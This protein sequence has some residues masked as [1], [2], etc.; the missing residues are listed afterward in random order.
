MKRILVVS[1]L[2]IASTANSQPYEPEMVEIK[3]GVFFMGSHGGYAESKPVHAVRVS[4]FYMGK[5][6]VTN[7]EFAAFIEDSGYVTEAE[8]IGT[9]R[10]LK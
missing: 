1:L 2:S 3:G 4:E 5:Y 7:Q 6:E 8:E 10:V 9:G